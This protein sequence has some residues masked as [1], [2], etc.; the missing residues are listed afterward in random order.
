MQPMSS[1]VPPQA[2]LVVVLD[3]GYGDLAIETAVLDPIGARL[4][5]RPC[6]GDAAAV[7]RAVQGADAILVRESPVDAEAVARMPGCRVVVR[8]GVG[9]DNVDLAACARAGIAVANVPDYGVEEVSDH[10]LALMLAVGRRIARRDAA[11]R[12]GQWGIGRIEPMHRFAGATLGLIGPAGSG[13][14]LARRRR[15]W[16]SRGCWCTIPMRAACRRTGSRP[17]ST[18]SAPRPM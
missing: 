15:R 5:L 13:G 7:H 6:H 11:V 16:D 8:Y 4:A 18:A 2:P 1:S 14:A 10:A 3:D 12:A 9:T 17:I